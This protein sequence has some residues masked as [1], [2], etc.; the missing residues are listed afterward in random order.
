MAVPQYEHMSL[1]DIL[2]FGLGYKDVVDALPIPREIRK[3]P[4]PYVCNVIYT[5]VGKDFRDWV[6]E[7]CKIRNEKLA[8]DHNTMI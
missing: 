2:D 6:S 8:S 5:L 7:R 3:M 4:R 1:D